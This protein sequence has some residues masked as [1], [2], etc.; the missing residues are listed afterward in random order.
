MV[1]P[2]IPVS[3]KQSTC[4]YCLQT[5]Q[6]IIQT[7]SWEILQGQV[8][9]SRWSVHRAAGASVTVTVKGWST[10]VTTGAGDPGLLAGLLI[11][12][13]DWR[14]GGLLLL[15]GEPVCLGNR[16]FG[17]SRVEDMTCS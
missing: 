17:R 15:K 13:L 7:F 16:D 11:P 5:L 9:L 6:S 14:P 3:D 10:G 2:L 12:L 1:L 8:D 4:Q